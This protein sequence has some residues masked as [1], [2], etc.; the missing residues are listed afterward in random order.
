MAV[1]DDSY[2]F[3]AIQDKMLGALKYFICVCEKYNIRYWAGGG[4]CL[5]ALRHEGF[6]PWDED[7]DVYVP[8]PDYER[9]WEICTT[10]E[11]DPKYRL[12]RTTAEKNYRHRVMQMVDLETTFINK[13]AVNDDIEHGVYIDIVP[14]DICPKSWISRVSQIYYGLLFSIFNVQCKP[15][16]HGNPIK[17]SLVGL[18]LFMIRDSQKRTSI[19]KHAEQKMI[20]KEW[21]ETSSLIELVGTVKTFI[22]PHKRSWFK[23]CS[24]TAKF[25]DIEIV[26]PNG[27]EEYLTRMY[28]DYMKLP[29]EEERCYKHHTVFV[30][31]NN[32]YIK[33][34]HIYYLSDDENGV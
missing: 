6:I 11:R 4:T 33:Y 25:E 31:L 32:S 2:G 30:D 9:L 23:D 15:E 18:L 22:H 1:K 34:K 12:C 10:K 14:L 17:N 20:W 8:R 7:L 16:Y 24:R 3:A 29:P 13:R 26:V 27:A 19:W 5:G 28:G 21:D